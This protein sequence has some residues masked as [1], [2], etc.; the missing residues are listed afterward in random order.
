MSKDEQVQAGAWA[1][2][3]AFPTLREDFTWSW[4]E[5][6]TRIVLDAIEGAPACK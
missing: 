1:L 3:D 6:A 2:W 5:K 4:F